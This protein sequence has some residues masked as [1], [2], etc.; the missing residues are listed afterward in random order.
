MCDIS[1][2]G[3]VYFFLGCRVCRPVLSEKF[4]RIVCEQCQTTYIVP[5]DKIVKNVLRLTCQKCGHVITTRVEKTENPSNSTLGK[6][7]KSGVN[8]PSRLQSESPSWYYSVDG[9]S[10]GPFTEIE[11]K[12]R[13]LT[14]KMAPKLEQCY[15]WRKSFSEWKPV[16][17]VEPFASALLMPPPPPPPVKPPPKS[18]SNLPPLF[19]GTKNSGSFEIGKPKSSPDLPGLKQRLQSS[20]GLLS[21]RQ[22]TSLAKLAGVE[23]N[24]VNVN[25]NDVPT[26][27]GFPVLDDISHSSEEDEESS[28]KTRVRGPMPFL[29]FQ[30]LDVISPSIKA[31]SK[32]GAAPEMVKP[33]PSLS[34][35]IRSK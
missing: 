32:D 26:H 25:S 15:I 8:T 3:G 13:L 9:E 16:L 21:E 35:G 5:D 2:Y 27:P 10:I 14:D 31:E 28:D 18:D 23:E 34:S 12:N 4:M 11:L 19:T 17:E 22:R 7:Q 6:W 24:T 20:N 30:S 33:F 29:S 1:T